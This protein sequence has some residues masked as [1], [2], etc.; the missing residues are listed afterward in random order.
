MSSQTSLVEKGKH[1]VAVAS[2]VLKHIEIGETIYG[3]TVDRCK[4]QAGVGAERCC[5]SYE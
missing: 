3:Q 4:Q 5:C 1:C 2:E